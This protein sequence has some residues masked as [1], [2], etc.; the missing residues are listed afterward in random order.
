MYPG[1]VHRFFLFLLPLLVSAVV[2][3]MSDV[4]VICFVCVYNTCCPLYKLNCGIKLISTVQAETVE[5]FMQEISN[6]FRFLHYEDAICTLQGS[7]Y[8]LDGLNHC[9][10]M[11]ILY[12]QMN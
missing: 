12:S 4:I 10:N 9:K 6:S 3:L 11:K 7:A 2:N 1:D 8:D 5:I